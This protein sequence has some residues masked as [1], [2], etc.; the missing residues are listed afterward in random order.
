[1]IVKENTDIMR[2][3]E[4]RILLWMS[5]FLTLERRFYE[6]CIF[7]YRRTQMRIIILGHLQNY[8]SPSGG[9]LLWEQN[10]CYCI[11][12]LMGINLICIVGTNI[13]YE[14]ETMTKNNYSIMTLYQE[15]SWSVNVQITTLIYPEIS[16]S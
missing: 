14:K 1:M 2:L 9:V 16:F 10:L 13:Y 15:Y 8:L 11:F 6:M 7:W 4:I 12:K 5:N 3:R